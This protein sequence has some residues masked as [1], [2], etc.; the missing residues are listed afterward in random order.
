M[1]DDEAKA[2]EDYLTSNGMQVEVARAFLR[3][4]AKKWRQREVRWT[5]T[6]G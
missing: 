3:K 1:R 5:S 2:I 4:Y 6:H